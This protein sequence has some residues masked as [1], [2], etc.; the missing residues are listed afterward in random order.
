EFTAPTASTP[1]QA[2]GSSG[3][4]PALPAS[5]A[6]ATTT[7]LCWSAYATARC[8]CGKQPCAMGDGTPTERLITLAPWLTANRIPA[9]AVCGICTDPTWLEPPIRTGRILAWG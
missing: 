8:N 5:P 2:A 1:A 4:L 6:L 9:A 3:K 7:T